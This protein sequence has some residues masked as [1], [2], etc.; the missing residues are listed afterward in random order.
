MNKTTI[1]LPA[2][3]HRGVQEMAR[4]THRRQADII[5]SAIEQFLH[6]QG[7]TLPRSIGAGDDAELAGRDSEDWLRR[8]WHQA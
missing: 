7:H 1:Y 8:Q 2:D 6:D 5:R 4:R 3:L